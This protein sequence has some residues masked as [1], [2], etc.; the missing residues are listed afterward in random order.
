MGLQ[1]QRINIGTPDAGNGDTVRDAFSKLNDNLDEYDV[2]ISRV[3]G[4]LAVSIVY[5]N[6]ATPQDVIIVSDASAGDSLITLPAANN[7]NAKPT[8][9]C[10]KD[11]SINVCSFVDPNGGTFT[12]DVQYQAIRL[13]PLHDENIWVKQG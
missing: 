2:I 1:T 5:E 4:I 12:V 7:S 9:C 11:S 8:I 6:S 13:V 10:K 3:M